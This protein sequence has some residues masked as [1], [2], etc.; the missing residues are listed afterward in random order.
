MRKIAIVGLATSTH[1]A[2]PF[3]TDWEMWGLP[4]D[5]GYWFR[6][7][8][9]F[10]MHD[11]ELLK[12]PESKR[13]KDYMERLR[14]CHIPLY[15][16][17]ENFLNPH[18]KKY[19]LIEVIDYIGD[20]FNSSI[21]YMIAL[22]IYEGCDEIGIWGVDM[23]DSEEYAY[24]R[25]NAEYLLGLAHGLGINLS[26]PEQSSLLTFNA[27]GIPLGAMFPHYPKR[28]GYL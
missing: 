19:P 4:W 5:N 10:E 9:L 15:M 20:Y 13:P 21:A 18:I 3:D 26:I 22:A 28:Y 14:T 16:Q 25:P 11:L 27:K 17:K 1:D 8:R 7:D 2:A 23:T 24:Q 6:Y 12:K